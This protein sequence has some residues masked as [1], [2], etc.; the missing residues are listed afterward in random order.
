MWDSLCLY[1]ARTIRAPRFHEL[2]RARVPGRR[3]IVM[4]LSACNRGLDEPLKFGKTRRTE[5]LE[6]K[7]WAPACS[8][9]IKGWSI[10][11]IDSPISASN[12]PHR[13]QGV[14]T[15]AEI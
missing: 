6:R 13:T 1:A 12:G 15:V 5:R 7:V 14:G 11:R 9:S 8:R 3:R 10:Q 4:R 2:W